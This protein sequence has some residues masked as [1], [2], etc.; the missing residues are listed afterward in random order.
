MGRKKRDAAKE[1]FWSDAI[2]RRE[3]SGLTIREFCRREGLT[4]CVDKASGPYRSGTT[5]RKR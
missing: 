5:N 3:Q 4:E 2:Q 1:Q